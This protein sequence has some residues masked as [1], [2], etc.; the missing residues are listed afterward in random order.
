MTPLK[1]GGRVGVGYN[2]PIRERNPLLFLFLLFISFI[3]FISFVLFILYTFALAERKKKTG[4]T[5][6]TVDFS[7]FNKSRK[8]SRC[9]AISLAVL[10]VTASGVLTGV[11][12]DIIPR[13]LDK[14]QVTSSPLI[15]GK[16]TTAMSC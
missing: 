1:T 6:P 11:S 2:L 5:G 4:K 9:T 3:S 10:I 16:P 15:S 12:M 7:C 14:L 13:I 8:L